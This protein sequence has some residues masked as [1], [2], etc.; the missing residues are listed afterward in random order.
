MSCS[1][2]SPQEP[3]EVKVLPLDTVEYKVLNIDE[4]QM[5]PAAPL[6]PK[7]EECDSDTND[8]SLFE[9]FRQRM[10][11]EINA[12]QKAKNSHIISEAKACGIIHYLKWRKNPS[13]YPDIKLSDFGRH[14]IREYTS[15]KRMVLIDVPDLGL[16]SVLAVPKK[17][18]L[19]TCVSF[20]DYRRVIHAGQM[21]DLVQYLHTDSNKNTHCG[22]RPVYERSKHEYFGI[23]RSYIRLHCKYCPG[24]VVELTAIKP[25]QQHKQPV[26]WSL[27]KRVFL[28]RE[29]Y[30]NEKSIDCVLKKYQKEFGTSDVPQPHTIHR[31]VQLFEE[32]GNVL[33]P[34]AW[35]TTVH[36]SYLK[37]DKPASGSN[38]WWASENGSTV[39]ADPGDAD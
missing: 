17:S 30:Q 7:V 5:T 21:F 38:C 31:L 24:C 34:A 4:N 16:Y 14:T 11:Y 36:E 6:I 23:P 2:S 9:M 39:P 19:D 26:T 18:D 12:L 32:T 10:T 27:E 29:F 25:R 15:A 35:L 13:E 22:Y 28:V 3:I 1:G 37:H 33:A 20:S 8:T